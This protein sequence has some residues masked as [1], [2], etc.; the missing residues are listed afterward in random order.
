MSEMHSEAEQLASRLDRVLPPGTTFV[1]PRTKDQLVNTAIDIASASFP[2]LSADAINRIETRILVAYRGQFPTKNGKLHTNGFHPREP[3][4]VKTTTR[5]RTMPVVLR[6]VAAA[7][8]V[9]VLLAGSVTA[10]SSSTLP[11]DIL[12]PV[13]RAVEQIELAAASSTQQRVEV[14]LNHAQR[15]AEEALILSA[16]RQP[17]E[18][19]LSE[20]QQN[21]AAAEQL[22]PS[23][24]ESPS[25]L[26]HVLEINSILD[27]VRSTLPDQPLN[28]VDDPGV[29]IPVETPT[30]TQTY[31]VTPT[32][33]DI[34]T[35]TF[36]PSETP[37][38]VGTATL[39]PTRTS[40]TTR[41][42]QTSTPRPDQT[43]TVTRTPS[44]TPTATRTSTINRTPTAT[45][46]RRNNPTRTV[47]VDPTDCSGNS[48][49]ARAT[50]QPQGTPGGGNGNQP[51]PTPGADNGN[52]G[53][54]NNGGGNGNNPTPDNGSGNGGGN[55]NDGGNGNANNPPGGDSGVTDPTPDNGNG[56]GGGNGNANNPPGATPA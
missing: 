1:P 32:E 38:P 55:G 30:S 8:L 26:A 44:R 47:D 56:N 14:Y 29:V 37:L 20:A 5:Q 35:P 54:N 28:E 22:D 34:P 52:G 18:L 12:Y 42:T 45:A 11:G 17:V 33:T 49:A 50:N 40:V 46:T 31:T 27:V 41:R 36:T 48:C 19:V 24:T 23:L 51:Q 9:F 4:L 39:A 43:A 7:V 53:G 15:R 16:R 6:W 21:V 3:V 2:V 13:K 10:A 25:L